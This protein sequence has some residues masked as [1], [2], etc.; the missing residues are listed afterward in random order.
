MVLRILLAIPAALLLAAGA[1]YLYSPPK[2]LDVLDGLFP[3]DGGVS[4]VG[5]AIPFA[6]G[7]RGMLDVW[8]P[9]SA[10]A[11][12]RPVLIFFYGGGWNSGR[13]R[14]YGF[15]AKAY[16]ARGFV[17]VMPDYRIGPEFRFPAFNQDGAAAIKWT[18]DTIA[19]YGG[20]PNRI[21][22]GGHSAGAYIAVMLA[23]DP[24]YLRDIGVDPHIVRAVAG[25]AGPYDFYPWDSPL[26][27]AAMSA[28]PDP[29]ATQPIHFA[30]VDAPPLWLAA[31]TADTVV[32]AR[33]ARNLA[34][35]E[36]VLG[37]RMT[38]LREYPGLSHNDLIM[39]VSKPFRHKAPVIDESVAFFKKA[40]AER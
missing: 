8:A 14:D 10:A 1:L 36:A 33:N 34:A 23:L 21:V 25:L 7:P 40:L 3:G 2:S 35:R 15:V 39:A 13:R 31:G 12:P 17:V 32:K 19:A 5:S 16:A 38:V 9:D 18:R 27:I 28:W 29:Q 24:Y 20:D 11:K 4:R 30:R 37:N 6:P 26:S 22:L